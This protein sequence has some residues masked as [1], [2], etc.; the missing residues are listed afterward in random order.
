MN[1]ECSDQKVVGES[2]AYISHTYFMS[3][4]QQAHSSA[5]TTLMYAKQLT[6]VTNS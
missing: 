5:P 1:L 2:G 6:S 4:F 3:T